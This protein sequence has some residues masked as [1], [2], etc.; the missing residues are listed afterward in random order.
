MA[1]AWEH[2]PVTAVFC[3]FLFGITAVFSTDGRKYALAAAGIVA[4]CFSMLVQVYLVSAEIK[5][6]SD[7]G[8]TGFYARV[9]E[10][11]E[12]KNGMSCLLET[13]DLEG[14]ILLYSKEKTEL[15][16]GD[17]IWADAVLKLPENAANPGQFS[18]RKYYFSKGIYYQGFATRIQI[19]K[20]ER[21]G[22]EYRKKE[23]Q[24]YIKRQ[25]DQ[26]YTGDAKNFVR[27]MILGDKTK[28]RQEIKDDLKESGL[29]HLMAVSGLHISLAGRSIYRLLRRLGIGFLISALAGGIAAAA[30]CG[31]TGWTVSSIRAILMLGVYFLSQIFGKHYDMLSAAAFAGILILLLR[32]FYIWDGGFLLSFTAVFVIGCINELSWKKRRILDKIRFPLAVQFGMLPVVVYLQYEVPLFAF[33]AN[34]LAVPVISLALPAAMIF[35]WIPSFPL[36]GLIA[37]MFQMVLYLSS[38]DYGVINI[39]HVPLLWVFL[40]YGSMVL[41]FKKKIRWKMQTKILILYGLLLMVIGIS[42]HQEKSIAFLDVGQGDCII[43]NTDAGVIMTDGGSSDV[44]NAGRYRILPYLKYCGRTKIKIAIVT[45]MDADHCSGILELLKMGKIEYLAL[46][47]VPRDA[48]YEKMLRLAK[49]TETGVFL[50]SKGRKMKGSDFF[51]EVLHPKK[52]STL[53]KNAASIVMQGKVLGYRVLLTGDVENEGEEEVQKEGIRDADVLKAGHHGSKNAT[54]DAFLRIVKPELTVLSCGKNNRYGHPHQ[55]VLKRLKK[56]K[57]RIWRTD[58][59]GALILSERKAGNRFIH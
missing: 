35:L 18:F 51:L 33:L 3:A 38:F 1:A 54:S 59:K 14:K 8:K 29:I 46:P 9:R 5:S 10:V 42:M 25:I 13:D 26:Q 31:L 53:S 58:R 50:L 44:K 28:V 21:S 34:A 41:I 11:Y 49:K 56:Y 22:A 40:C 27:A 43:M 55:E 6:V 15:F 4:G 7:A 24:T 20:R 39:G 16:S 36:H 45:H 12:K 52:G 48:A 47:D 23:I 2:H 57:S 37:K 32:P 19:V 30:Y 17:V